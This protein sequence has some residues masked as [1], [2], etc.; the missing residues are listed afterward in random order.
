VIR[1]ENVSVRKGE[2]TL[3]E[4]VSLEF[5]PGELVCL[6]G[7]NG[8]GKS[9]LVRVAAGSVTP[10]SG[11]VSFLGVPI[12]TFR[13]AELARRRAVVSQQSSVAFPF[14]VAEVV[15]LGRHPHAALSEGSRDH[16]AVESALRRMDVAHLAEREVTTLS[17]GERQRV[18]IARAMAQLASN[19]PAEQTALF[20]DEPTSN[21]DLAH[22]HS[23]LALSRATSRE[24]RVT[25]VALHD[26]N[27]ASSYGD[28]I[29]VLRRGRVVADGP[30]GRV[31][32]SEL[33]LD[34]FGLR[35]LVLPHP[36]LDCPLVVSSGSH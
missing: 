29:V 23:A 9:T 12:D 27:L 35:T 4:G 17:G 13:N 34:V 6:V 2:V 24:G 10:T 26:L 5:R 28:R 21:L 18:D 32:T 36:E 19:A 1:L 25:I 30:P 15:L 3:L 33:I 11:R 7:P 16:L 8:A 31:L 14:S 22:Q 20:L